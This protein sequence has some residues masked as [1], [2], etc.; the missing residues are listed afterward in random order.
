MTSNYRCTALTGQPQPTQWVEFDNLYEARKWARSASTGAVTQV[1]ERLPSGDY[2]E[3]M[4]WRGVEWIHSDQLTR[5]F[6]SEL[7]EAGWYIGALQLGSGWPILRIRQKVAEAIL[8]RTVIQEQEIEDL[9]WK[10][11]QEAQRAAE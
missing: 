3:Y 10:L 7:M 2:L 8:N 6:T 4:F 11:Y 1:W 5:N 9:I